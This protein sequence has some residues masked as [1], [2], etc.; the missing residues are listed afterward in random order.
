MATLDDLA[1][2]KF[3]SMTPEERFE[4]IRELRSLRRVQVIKPGKVKPTT[5]EKKP[6]KTKLQFT[7]ELAGL[8]QEQLMQLMELMNDAS[9]D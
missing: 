7:G 2:P 3:L 6:P 8:S 4:L 9:T 5:R 1:N